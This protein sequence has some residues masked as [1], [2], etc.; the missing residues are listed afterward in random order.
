MEGR[1]EPILGYVPK[2]YKRKNSGSN[3][4]LICSSMEILHSKIEYVILGVLISDNIDGCLRLTEPNRANEKRW[5]K[6]YSL[7][8]L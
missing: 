3:N 2:N 6:H 7:T 8:I 5:S 4:G 1:K